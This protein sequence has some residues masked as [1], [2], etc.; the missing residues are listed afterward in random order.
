MNRI[1]S[2]GAERN[3]A[4]HLHR[5]ALFGLLARSLSYPAPGHQ[6][7]VSRSLRRFAAPGG[8]RE[9]GRVQ[10]LLRRVQ[11]AWAAADEEALRAEYARLFLAGGPVSL[12]ETAYGDGRRIAGRTVELAD[13]SGFY[14]A[15]GLRLSDADPDLP[16]HLCSELE[17]HSAMLLKLAYAGRGGWSPGKSVTA[18]AAREFIED[19]LGRWVAALAREVRA[20]R[21]ASP[22][23]ELFGLLTAVV[24]LE[25][26]QFRARPSPLSGRLPRDFMQDD[27]FACPK[28]GA[29]AS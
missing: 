20:H 6:R 1:S 13:I 28:Q 8:A 9:D 23:R 24:S 21:A 3:A 5:A 4:G 10:R 7:A 27:E 2:P 11:R 12:H 25:S 17:F 29:P 19:H 22:Y 16:D 15:F 26:R 18:R 14:T